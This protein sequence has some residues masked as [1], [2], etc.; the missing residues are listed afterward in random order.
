MSTYRSRISARDSSLGTCVHTIGHESSICVR[1]CVCMCPSASVCLLAYLCHPC[2]LVT[3]LYEHPHTQAATRQGVFLARQTFA[4][5]SAPACCS[6]LSAC[7]P[8]LC[9]PVPGP[10]AQWMPLA[11]T[12]LKAVLLARQ[13]MT[14]VCMCVCTCAVG[15]VCVY[16]CA[17]KCVAVHAPLGSL[18]GPLTRGTY[19][20]VYVCVCLYTHL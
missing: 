15:G 9:A 13:H 12:H 10:P 7:V 8:V 11:P 17:P 1:V 6:L 18:P 2:A 3:L 4:C 20:Y 16:M 5:L 14:R 19:V